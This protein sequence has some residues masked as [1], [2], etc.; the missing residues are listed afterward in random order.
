MEQQKA[1]K[2]DFQKAYDAAVGYLEENVECSV[3]ELQDY[4]G[5]S[6]HLCE[7]VIHQLKRNDEAVQINKSSKLWLRH[8][9]YGLADAS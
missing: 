5:V 6:R 9:S 8:K 7:S 2:W 3:A 1:E 4:L